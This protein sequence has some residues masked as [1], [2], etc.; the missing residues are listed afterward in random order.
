[1][2]IHLALLDVDGTLRQGRQWNPGAVE[3]IRLLHDAG[4]IVALCSGRGATSMRRITTD[5][6]EVS[7]FASASGSAVWRRASAGW[8]LVAHRP[9]PR[10]IIER[11]VCVAGELGLE[12]WAYTDEQWL[13][14]RHTPII[15]RETWL[16]ED[17][18]TVADFRAAPRI[19][20]MLF[21]GAEDR[22]DELKGLVHSPET[23]LVQSGPHYADIV[24]REAFAAKGGDVLLAETGIGW[25]EVLAV[26]DSENDLGML[27]S[28]AFA[29]VVGNHLEPAMIPAPQGA[30]RLVVPD[31]QA[32]LETVRGLLS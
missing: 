32:A 18:A 9:L 6:P 31:T 10:A 19:G 27:G 13:I 16:V 15:D 17:R 20:K 22:L 24:T 5:L 8:E 23:V 1:M 14:A 11:A 30:M 28:A 7:Y 2:P 3:L 12:L 4:A 21:L 26:G 29:I 25:D